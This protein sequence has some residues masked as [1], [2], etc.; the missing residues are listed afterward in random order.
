MNGDEFNHDSYIQNYDGTYSTIREQTPTSPTVAPQ[1]E[2]EIQR[3]ERINGY[4]RHVSFATG[5]EDRPTGTTERGTTENNS[6]SGAFASS[7]PA[8]E[9]TPSPPNLDD[10][11]RPTRRIRRSHHRTPGLHRRR[12]WVSEDFAP[13]R[14][15]NVTNQP[16]CDC[17]GHCPSTCIRCSDEAVQMITDV[18]FIV[19][20][21]ARRMRELLEEHGL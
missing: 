20:Y 13:R 19:T 5:R 18:T 17:H 6:Y 21:W 12:T 7:P 8:S 16:D 2:P 14:G 15:A 1:Q 10:N 3:Y 11:P 4:H 9:R